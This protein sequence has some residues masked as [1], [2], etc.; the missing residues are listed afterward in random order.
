MKKNRY[1]KKSKK[2]SVRYLVIFIIFEV[3]FTAS[4]VPLLIFYGPFQNVKKEIVGAAMTTLSHQFIA[5]I[6]LTDQQINNVLKDETVSTIY[7]N[8][9][10]D[11]QFTEGHGSGVELDKVKG[12]TFTGYMLVVKDPNKVK[13]GVAKQLGTRGERTSQI[14]KDNNAIAAINAGG[15]SDNQSSEKWTGTGANPIGIIISNG[16]TKCCDI[17]NQNTKSDIVGLTNKGVLIVGQHSINELKKD[18]V[19]Q[20]ISFGPALVVNGRPTIKSGDGGWGH[21]ARTAIGQRRDKSILFLVIDGR[22]VSSYGA[23]LRDI[24]DIMINEYGAL[25][26]ANLD[27]GSST[28][29]YYNGEIINNPC[30]SLGER[31]VPTAFYALP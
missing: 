12:K 29:L 30:N 14:A 10:N 9:V 5:K 6:F 1:S 23:T 15:F 17:K 28:T 4:T 18:N 31:T 19:T 8:N 22:Q 21:S 13:L 26:A 25:N 27:G 20:A 24:Q 11:I 7:Q 3:V 16:V 2:L